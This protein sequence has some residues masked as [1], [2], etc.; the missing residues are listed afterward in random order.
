MLNK[1][2]FDQ[3]NDLC[4]NLGKSAGH[5][6]IISGEVLKRDMLNKR[7]AEAPYAMLPVDNCLK[8]EAEKKD[9][10][11]KANNA[12]QLKTT[13]ISIVFAVIMC[14]I[15]TSPIAPISAP[16]LIAGIIII[17]F[18]HK[19]SKEK[20]QEEVVL[21]M[22]LPLADAEK[23]DRIAIE[24]N[25]R[26]KKEAQD[27]LRMELQPEYDRIEK[28]IAEESEN[29]RQYDYNAIIN[30]L[31]SALKNEQAHLGYMRWLMESG[32]ADSIKEALQL[33]DQKKVNDE[34]REREMQW[35]REDEM[36]KDRDRAEDIEREERA[37]RDAERRYREEVERQ[38]RNRREDIARQKQQRY[39]DQKRMEYEMN[40]L[41]RKLE[42]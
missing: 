19:K 23:K 12:V 25:G 39:E 40:R 1:Q 28:R 34:R 30:P 9:K 14:I 8:A 31:Y 20:A 26:R 27:A 3:L 32:R 42:E 13:I 7:V 4:Y 6:N 38:E 17:Y 11:V 21:S 10:L 24:E 16:V 15:L 36:R 37:R 29:K 41:N 5:S 18:I 2:E 35:R 22:I 33:L